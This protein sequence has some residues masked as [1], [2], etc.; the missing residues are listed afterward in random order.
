MAARLVA[1]HGYTRLAFADPLKEMALSVDPL[2]PTEWNGGGYAHVRLSSLV[3]SLGWD[4]AKAKYPEVRRVLQHIGQTVR[5]LDPGFWIRALLERSV[6]A[7]GPI[8]VTDMRYENEYLT[9]ER[10]G[11]IPV[12]VS[13]PGAG[14][15]GA[16]GTHDSETA[17]DDFTFTEGILNDGSLDLLYARTDALITRLG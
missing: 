6:K 11:L 2:I 4:Y 3:Q 1:E 8:V 13:R 7:D 17:L 12:R 15:S 5:T 10:A 16:A 14:L 9:L